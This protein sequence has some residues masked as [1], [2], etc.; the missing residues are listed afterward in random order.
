MATKFQRLNLYV[1]GVKLSSGCTSDFVGRGYVLEIQYGRRI[2]G[3]GSTSYFAGF[4]DIYVVSKTTQE[5]MTTY[6]T[7]ESPAIMADAT[8]CRKFNMVAN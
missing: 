1:F 5:F 8:A 7:S 4:T 3:T 2:T 6:E